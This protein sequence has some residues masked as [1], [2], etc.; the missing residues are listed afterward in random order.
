MPTK[1]KTQNEALRAVYNH[2]SLPA[3]LH[4]ICREALVAA[5]NPATT[6]RAATQ[7]AGEDTGALAIACTINQKLGEYIAGRTYLLPDDLSALKRFYECATD[8]DSGGHD[9]SKDAMARLCEIGVIRSKGFGRHETTSFGD[10]VLERSE[11]EPL[12]LPLKTLVERNAEAA[13]LAAPISEDSGNAPVWTQEMI[14]NVYTQAEALGKRI[15]HKPLADEP[16]APSVTEGDA[17]PPGEEPEWAYGRAKS[18]KPIPKWEEI[19]QCAEEFG[20]RVVGNKLSFPTSEGK[21]LFDI[22]YAENAP[23]SLRVRSV[24]KPFRVTQPEAAARVARDAAL[25]EAATLV[26]SRRKAAAG[27]SVVAAAIRCLKSTA[28]A[29]PDSAREA[30]TDTERLEWLLAQILCNIADDL[31][32]GIS[33]IREAIDSAI[34]AT[35]GKA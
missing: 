23:S 35:K 6:E 25:E 30:M 9:V 27:H 32:C 4:D 11:G 26:E 22:W 15:Q 7:P 5:Y 10:Y 2:P 31:D 34:L 21:V 24:C 33:E 13:R 1:P 12:R 16:A 19:Q 3:E 28:P 29:A 20:G 14:D 17:L 18:S 8:F